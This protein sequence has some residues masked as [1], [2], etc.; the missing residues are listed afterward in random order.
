MWPRSLE[1]VVGFGQGSVTVGGSKK[2]YRTPRGRAICRLICC[3]WTV[4]YCCLPHRGAPREERQ[5]FDRSSHN[6]SINSP[7]GAPKGHREG[8]TSNHPNS[9]HLNSLYSQLNISE[10]KQSTRKNPNSQFPN[11]KY[12]KPCSLN[13][14]P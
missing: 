9:N 1:N 12:L 7:L 14:K 3:P 11:S 5:L 2:P 13:P 10:F 8:E 6:L 4:D